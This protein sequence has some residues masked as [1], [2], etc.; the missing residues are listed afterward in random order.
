MAECEKENN[1]DNKEKTKDIDVFLVFFASVM[2]TATHGGYCLWIDGHVS[3]SPS[4]SKVLTSSPLPSDTTAL[5][6]PNS[7]V[8]T[9]RRATNCIKMKH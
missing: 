7:V 5:Y 8:V 3:P 1:G 2:Y 6:E 9:C 4:N